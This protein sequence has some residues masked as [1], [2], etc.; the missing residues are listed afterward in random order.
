MST[1][2]VP[3]ANLAQRR[4]TERRIRGTGSGN[5]NVEERYLVNATALLWLCP[6]EPTD[7]T[8]A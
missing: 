8:V 7:V 1:R 2:H 3:E 4:I 5:V 6:P